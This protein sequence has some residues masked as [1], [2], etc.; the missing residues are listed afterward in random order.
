MRAQLHVTADASEV[1]MDQ[2]RLA[3]IPAYFEQNYVDTGRLA[4]FQVV[5]AR[6]GQVVLRA[7]CGCA[8]LASAARM[9]PDTLFRIYSMTKPITSVAL[10]TLYEQGRFQLDDPVHRHLPALADLRVFAGGGASQALTSAAQRPVTIRDLLTHTSGLTYG[11][12]D[13]H[14]VDAI[15]RARGI[16]GPDRRNPGT[17][18]ATT[19]EM[20]DRLSEVPLLFSPGTQWSYSVATDVVGRLVEVISGQRLDVFM[21]QR[22]FGPLGMV[23]TVFDLRADHA[24]RLAAN[25]V[26]AA[27]GSLEILDP[28][29]AASALSIPATFHSGGGGLVSSA[30]D[31]HRFTQMLLGGGT[32]DGVR[33][34][35]RKTVEFMTV[36]HLPTG[37][38][39]ATMGMAT[40]DGYSY[41]GVGFGLGFA[42]VLDPVRAQTIGSAGEYNWGG[43]A[44]TLFWVD[45]AE[46]L[47]AMLF[48]QVMPS[49]NDTTRR[50]LQALVYQALAD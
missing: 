3:R 47:V 36:N 25:Y 27:D 40:W 39:L 29:G 18:C 42:V 23:D 48:A 41:L 50:E 49:V 28:A 24:D 34:L 38:D 26:T 44:S 10:M 30:H 33:V 6:Q 35:G 4:G 17:A 22:I 9:A 19:A 12:M 2:Q 45:P 13:R 31:Y 43:A 37:G 1:G 21:Q 46:E 20:V 7:E 32:L 14:P 11:F 8:D 16:T 15:Y 5:V